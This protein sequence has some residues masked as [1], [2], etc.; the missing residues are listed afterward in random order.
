M[1]MKDK[2]K[3]LAG[4][5]LTLP[6]VPFIYYG[7]EIGMTGEKPDENIRKTYVVGDASEEAGFYHWKTLE[8]PS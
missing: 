3:V 2:M 7:E 4:M 6:G 8:R 1:R 5:Y